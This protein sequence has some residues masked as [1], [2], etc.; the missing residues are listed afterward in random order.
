M[1]Y[2]GCSL[3][4]VPR[5]IV[6]RLATACFSENLNHAEINLYAIFSFTRKLSELLLLLSINRLRRYSRYTVGMIRQLPRVFFSIREMRGGN[7]RPL[8]RD[9]SRDDNAS[10]LSTLCVTV[11]QIK[12]YRKDCTASPSVVKHSREKRNRS[13]R[14]TYNRSP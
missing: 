1:C 9:N 10:V 2:L 14:R 11:L 7:A 3:S 5:H 12:K 13:T 8:P 6:A 4:F